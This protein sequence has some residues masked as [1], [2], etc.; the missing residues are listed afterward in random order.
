MYIQ[1][2][3]RTIL[4]TLQH[5]TEV[6]G[7]AHTAGSSIRNVLKIANNDT[8]LSS[9]LQSK[10]FSSFFN[11]LF[12]HNWSELSDLS[13]K[14]NQSKNKEKEKEKQREK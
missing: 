3:V 8:T 2:H 10:L 9:R 12:F 5:G 14:L 13:A 11:G 7:S 1:T 4:I 6:C